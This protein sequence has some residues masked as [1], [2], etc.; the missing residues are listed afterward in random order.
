VGFGERFADSQLDSVAGKDAV[1]A[2]D[3]QEFCENL[4]DEDTPW[5]YI[6]IDPDA[7]VAFRLG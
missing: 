4:G 6:K 3:G 5:W 7:R 1:C 2:E